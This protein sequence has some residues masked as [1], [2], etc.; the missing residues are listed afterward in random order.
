MESTTVA[1]EAKITN[2]SSNNVVIELNIPLVRSMS[3]GEE[4]IQIALN[5][6]GGRV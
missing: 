6:A 1:V 2:R 4:V 3:S 5:A